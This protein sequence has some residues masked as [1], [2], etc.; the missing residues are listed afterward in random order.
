MVQTHVQVSA[1]LSEIELDSRTN[2]RVTK[3]IKELEILQPDAFLQAY[4]AAKC[5][6]APASDSAGAA[7][8]SPRPL[9]GS[10]GAAL[11]LGKGTGE[12][13]GHMKMR[14]LFNNT[15]P[16]QFTE[17][18]KIAYKNKDKAKIYQL[19]YIELTGEGASPLPRPS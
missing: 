16:V 7:Q 17:N 6:C 14:D 1:T 5:D 2:I 19:K 4:N 12:K 9:A 15:V 18:G 13:R 3:Y 11:R 10:K 8:H